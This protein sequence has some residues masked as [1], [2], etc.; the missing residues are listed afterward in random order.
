[1]KEPFILGLPHRV[2]DGHFLTTQTLY[3][4]VGHNSGNLAFAHA[5]VSHL[6]GE[7]RAIAWGADPKLINATGDIGVLPAANQFG[8]HVDYT[9]LAER[10]STLSCKIVMIGLGAQSNVG[11]AIPVVP[12]GTVNWVREIAKRN[13]DGS[14]NISVRGEFSKKV[15][16]HYGLGDSV[17]ALG[18]P[19]LFT[20]PDPELGRT[21]AGNVR[22]IKRVAVPA[23]HPNWRHLGKIEA[24]LA[25]MVSA[26]GGSYVGQHA[27]EMMQLTRGEARLMDKAKLKACRDY[28][29]PE[30]DLEEFT[31]WSERHGNLFFDV[32][33][34]MEHYRRFDFVI[35]VRIHGVMLALQAGLPGVVIAHDSRTLEL[36]QTMMV[37]HVLAKDVENGITR[38]QLPEMF[39]FDAEAFDENRRALAKRYVKFLEANELSP[40]AWL[41]QIADYKP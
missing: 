32:P 3:D 38:E 1:M 11:G 10:F 14:P 2:P 8:A 35:G 40:V 21:I 37:P 24:S 18:C 25:R 30:M 22:N 36:C 26:T 28:A 15:L 9:K 27:L 5:V 33:S 4:R 34:W 31:R 41:K 13:H 19:S 23:G 39:T 7:A 6:G 12:E 29:A 17:V 16:E 20:N